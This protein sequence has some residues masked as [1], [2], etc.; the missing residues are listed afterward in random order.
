MTKVKKTVFLAAIVRW[1]RYAEGCSTL[2][3]ERNIRISEAI[4]QLAAALRAPYAPYNK[5]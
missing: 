4:E 2:R 5:L 3:S 1:F